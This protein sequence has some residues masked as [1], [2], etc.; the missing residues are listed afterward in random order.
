MESNNINLDDSAEELYAQLGGVEVRKVQKLDFSGT[1]RLEQGLREERRRYDALRALF[2]NLVYQ[3]GICFSS[4]SKNGKEDLTKRISAQ[5]ANIFGKLSKN[6]EA[7]NRALIRHKGAFGGD[8]IDK[9]T[10]YEI[11]SGAISFDTAV[12][13]AISKGQ[14]TDSSQFLEKLNRGFE[15]FWSHSINNFL[16]K[17]PR[18]RPELE[19]LLLSLQFAARYFAA[20]EKNSPITFSMGGK[21]VSL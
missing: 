1:D 6:P 16:L 8:Q 19:R 7:G 5:F 14:G 13:H 2:V 9:K 4:C 20:I 12:V 10:D 15:T 17:I 21:P 11:L 3:V 18:S